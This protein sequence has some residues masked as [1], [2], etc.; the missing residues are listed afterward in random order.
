MT[1]DRI[2]VD[3]DRYYTVD[4]NRRGRSVQDDLEITTKLLRTEH[5]NAFY[6]SRVLNIW[7]TLPCTIRQL[8]PP[9]ETT[10]SINHF[11]T[12]LYSHYGDRNLQIY[13]VKN[14]CT[15]VSQ[16]RYIYVVL[17]ASAST[18]G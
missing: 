6:N 14:V 8:N 13:D 3:I 10:R 17:L 18:C 12:V 7:Y 1:H 16:C 4:N 15:K 9:W 11:K 2:N 5:A